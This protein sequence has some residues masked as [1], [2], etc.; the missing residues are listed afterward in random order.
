M[1]ID[2]MP[3]LEDIEGLRCGGMDETKDGWEDRKNAYFYFVEHILE[4]VAG[5]KE[6]K[7]DKYSCKI[8]AAVSISDEAFALLLL[9]NSWEVFFEY[10]L[11]NCEAGQKD[12]QKVKPKYTGKRGGSR[13]FEGWTRDGIAA[14]NR[15]CMQIVED[16]RSTMGDLFEIEFLDYMR[17]K[18]GMKRKRSAENREECRALRSWNE[19]EEDSMGN[20]EEDNGQVDGII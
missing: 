12:E 16:R 15:L 20:V 18:R 11:G 17:E 13:R 14:Y 2:E 3:A 19:D 10:A 8:S 1:K 9:S 4:C 6:W 5:K 7:K